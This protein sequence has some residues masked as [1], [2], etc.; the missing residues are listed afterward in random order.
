M[1]LAG[2]TSQKWLNHGDGTLMNGVYCLLKRN[3]KKIPGPSCHVRTQREVLFG[4]NGAHLRLLDSRRTVRN[5]YLVC[6]HCPVCGILLLQPEWTKTVDDL[7]KL[8]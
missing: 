2:G 1:A 3:F 4:H 5:D 8:Q 6:I 7:Y